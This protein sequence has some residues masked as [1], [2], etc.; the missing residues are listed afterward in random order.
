MF[1]R[2]IHAFRLGQPQAIML[3]GDVDR[4]RIGCSEPKPIASR[5][6]AKCDDRPAGC[7]SKKS[8]DG[9]PVIARSESDVAIPRTQRLERFQAD[10]KSQC[11]LSHCLSEQLYQPDCS[12]Q[13]D[14]APG[15]G[16]ASSLR[17][18]Q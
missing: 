17:F 15:M 7:S 1:D 5:F 6:V 11:A 18:S 16:I 4:T 14:V 13:A 12:S 2:M 9:G 10:W 8:A 3:W